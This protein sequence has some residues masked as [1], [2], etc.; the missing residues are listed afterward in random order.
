MQKGTL[1]K[2]QQRTSKKGTLSY[3]FVHTRGRF[4]LQEENSP[5]SG[6]LSKERPIKIDHPVQVSGMPASKGVNDTNICI[7][8][9]MLVNFS[10]L[11]DQFV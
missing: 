6:L 10:F 2:Q 4:F 11:Y 9:F 8:N 1:K 7:F 5:T 3:S